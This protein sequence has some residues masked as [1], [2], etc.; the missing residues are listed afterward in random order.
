MTGKL[1]LLST[2]R[3]WALSTRTMIFNLHEHAGEVTKVKLI[4]NDQN[5]ITSS[6]DKSIFFWNVEKQKRVQS[7]YHS[8][9][10]VNAFDIIPES[11]MIIS[12]GQDRKITYW[13]TRTP[14]AVYFLVT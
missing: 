10:S 11:N 13:D 8:F 9:G 3:L 1:A 2:V 7:F 6:R 12:T 14:V 5:L 4:D